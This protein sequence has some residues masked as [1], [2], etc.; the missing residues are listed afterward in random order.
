MKQVKW[1]SMVAFV[2]T[3]SA[4]N[5]NGTNGTNTDTTATTTTTTTTTEN[6]SSSGNYAAMA[7]SFRVNSQAGNYLDPKSG[8]PIKIRYDATTR[9]AVNEETNQ[10]VW[11]YVDRRNWWVYSADSDTWN[12]VGEARME[13]NT[14]QYKSAT[15]DNW[16][17]YD[18]RWAQDD[19][20]YM[21]SMND[22]TGTGSTGS[23]DMSS[24]GETKVKD[25]GNKVKD[26]DVKVKTSKDGDIKLKDKQTGDKVK[27]N[28]DNGKVKTGH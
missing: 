25:N 21:S 12:R 10:P 15:D 9:R 16:V 22:T 26:K 3:L 24:N 13:N 2:A 28:A 5:G 8:K 14:L 19:Q 11:R 4:C 17:N 27:Y 7:D 23:E 18:Q 20:R 1:L 6:A